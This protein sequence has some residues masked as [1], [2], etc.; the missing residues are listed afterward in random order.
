MFDFTKAQLQKIVLHRVGNQSLEEAL[1]L[2]EN[3]L[4]IE[5]E[6]LTASLLNYFLH[7]FSGNEM[8]AFHHETDLDLNE[9]YVYAKNIF[10]K[11]KFVTQSVSIAKHLYQCSTHPKIKGG[12]LYVTLLSGVLV[13]GK[14]VSVIGIFKSETKDTFL[15]VDLVDNAFQVEQN[16]GTSIDRL[17]KGCLVIS[18]GEDENF[19]VCIIDNLNKSTEAQY[20]KDHFLN[21]RP[22]SNDFHQTNQFMN[23]AK[24]FV[25]KQLAEEFVVK[26][27]DQIDLLNRSVEYFK[28]HETFDKDG[29]EK[30]VFKNKEIIESFRSFDESYRQDHDIELEDNFEI[31]S[32]AVKKQSRVFKS[33]LKLDKNFHIYIHGDRNLIEQGVERDGR[34][35]YKIYFEKEQ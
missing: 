17:D 6:T 28:K 24:E 27:T 12:E 35:Y 13:E 20:W 26:K 18:S 22:V 2:S 34:K 31:S 32:Q 10:A 19:Q 1:V 11:K 3:V 9:V 21:V 29:F 25:T 7:A 5:D 15:K 8:Y 33:V 4:E 30:E 23:I 14:P 16:E